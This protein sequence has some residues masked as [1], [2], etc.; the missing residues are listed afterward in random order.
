MLKHRKISE[1]ENFSR[2]SVQ[3]EGTSFVSFS[4]EDSLVTSYFETTNETCSDG[5][6]W[7]EITS[8]TRLNSHHN[9]ESEFSKYTRYTG[10]SLNTNFPYNSPYFPKIIKLLSSLRQHSNKNLYKTS[11]FPSNFTVPTRD[12]GLARA[13][14]QASSLAGSNNDIRGTRRQ[15]RN[16]AGSSGNGSRH[17]RNSSINRTDTKDNMKDKMGSSRNNSRDNLKYSGLSAED[18]I[19]LGSKTSSFDNNSQNF[20]RFLVENPIQLTEE[21]KKLYCYS[22]KLDKG[23][24]SLGITAEPD[25]NNLGLQIKSIIA[26]GAI[27]KTDKLHIGDILTKINDEPLQDLNITQA[28]NTIRHHSLLSKVVN[29]NYIPKNNVDRIKADIKNAQQN[30]KDGVSQAELLAM[31]GALASKPKS[32]MGSLANLDTA[33]ALDAML[34]SVNTPEKDPNSPLNWSNNTK[35]YSL[36]KGPSGIGI[37]I[38]GGIKHSQLPTGIYIKEIKKGSPADAVGLSIGDRIVNVSIRIL[39]YW[40]FFYFFFLYFR[41]D[42]YTKKTKLSV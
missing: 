32:R 9:T 24:T 6:C 36:N 40:F 30:S 33:L 16:S 11:Y 1:S 2:F 34:N 20:D 4:G 31:S 39:D 37:I 7:S 18:I 8:T 5:S 29:I 19:N 15:R 14:S 38:V 22:L 35:F 25:K 13:I 23:N 17:S 3:S 26:G 21:M 28:R 27:Y 42:M 41:L 10:I 12:P